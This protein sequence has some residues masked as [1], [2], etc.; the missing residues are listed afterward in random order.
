MQPFAAAALEPLCV[1]T[2]GEKMTVKTARW[3]LATA[4][5]FAAVPVAAQHLGA[6]STQRL[7]QVDKQL[8]SDAFQG[9]GTAAPIEPTVTQYIADQLKAAGVQPGGDIVN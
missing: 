1:R 9:R 6:F 4:F 8:S 7:S 5:A 2:L 3:L